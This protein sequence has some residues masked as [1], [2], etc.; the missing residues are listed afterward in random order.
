M[1]VAY[2]ARQLSLNRIV[3]LKLIQTGGMD[4]TSTRRFLRM[5]ALA[6]ATFNHPNIVQIYDLGEHQGLVYLAIEYV[7]GGTLDRLIRERSLPIRIVAELVEQI[8][9]GLGFVHQLGVVHRDIKPSNI[10]L[11]G[12]GRPRP[13]QSGNPT[14]VELYGTAKISD[15]GLSRR[16]R[17]PTPED[18]AGRGDPLPGGDTDVTRAGTILGTPAYMSPEQARGQSH[19]VGPT[20]DI[21][22]L[23]ATLYE[24]LTGRRPFQGHAPG[25][26]EILER[27]R[28]GQFTAVRQ[29]NPAVPGVLEAICHKCLAYDPAERYPTGE[30]LADD[31]AAFRARRPTSVTPRSWWGWLFGSR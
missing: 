31:L 6:M 11:T 3:V 25:I 22:S 13:T 20:A 16:Y 1:G 4:A 23:G 5:E 19:L 8:A 26:F 27:L 18:V 24:L 10:L 12:P 2:L 21:F 29:L 17:E 30:E 28:G 14:A 9:R 7:P 15:F